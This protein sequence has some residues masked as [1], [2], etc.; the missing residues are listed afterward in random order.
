MQ[1]IPMPVLYGVFLYMGVTS[2]GGVQVR[3]FMLHRI[4]KYMIKE[5]VGYLWQAE[6]TFIP[7]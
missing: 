3:H 6:L 2:L 5:P 4:I 1:F 7:I